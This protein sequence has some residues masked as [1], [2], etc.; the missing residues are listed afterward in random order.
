MHSIPGTFFHT[1]ACNPSG[2]SS[3]SLNAPDADGASY[4]LYGETGDIGSPEFSAIALAKD[5]TD[6]TISLNALSTIYLSSVVVKP[7]LVEIN[8]PDKLRLVHFPNTRDDTNT[9]INFLY[10]DAVGNLQSSAIQTDYETLNFEISFE[11]GEQGIR[12]VL[13]P[14]NC[15]IVVIGYS[16]TKTLSGTDDA[17]IYFATNDPAYYTVTIPASTTINNSTFFPSLNLPIT[18]NLT[19]NTQ[20]VV[21]PEKITPGGKVFLSIILEKI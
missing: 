8:S 6:Y 20:L 18:G 11:S 12:T 19:S 13:I 14:Y 2:V 10:T 16:V 15:K 17:N 9:P 1:I 4:L 5:T 3:L 21:T 7:D